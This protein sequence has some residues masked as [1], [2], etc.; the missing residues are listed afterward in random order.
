VV[1]LLEVF[2]PHPRAFT[3]A[4]STLLGQLVEMIPKIH[5]EN[6]QPGNTQPE[7]TQPVSV[8]PVETGLAPSPQMM[9]SGSIES[10]SID[11]GSIHAAREALRGKKPE[12]PEQLPQQ[13][14]KSVASPQVPRQIPTWVPKPAPTV[15]SR[16]LNGTWLWLAI[17]VLAIAL[18][19][20]MAPKV[21]RWAVSLQAWQHWLVKGAGPASTVSEQSGADH[22]SA[23]PRLPGQRPQPK[24]LDELRALADHGDPDAEWQM[25]V[26]CHNGEDVLQDDVQAMLWF[27][28][29]AEQGN[30]DAQA[31]L[32]AYYW[33]GRGVPQDLSKAYMWSQI[34]LSGGDENSKSRLEGLA[35]QMTHAQ[36]AAARQQAEAWIHTHNQPAKSPAN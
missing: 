16:P 32:G 29:A 25:G 3:K 4:H 27:Q 13:I 22:S 30:V 28:L 26:R 36:V 9:K 15:R 5:G 6:T 10:G 2:S 17:A 34:A 24:S 1:G 35:S 20:L 31:T 23:G 18:G 8:S 11:L 33:A 21:E 14:P 7:K 19:Y 12:V